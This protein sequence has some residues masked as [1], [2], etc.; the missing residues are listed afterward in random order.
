MFHPQYTYINKDVTD[1]NARPLLRDI[2][3]DGELVYELPTLEEIKEYSKLHLD[4]LWEEY[5]RDLNPQDYPV[6]L[7]QKCYDNKMKIIKEVRESINQ[8]LEK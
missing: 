4:S 7:S 6:D 1:F 8:K 3:K 2:F 5:K